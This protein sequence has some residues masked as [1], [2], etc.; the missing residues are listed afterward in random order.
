MKKGFTLIELLAVIVILAIIALIATPIV[1]NIISESKKS[2]GLRGAEMYL[3]AVEQSISI[4]KMN[5]ISFNPNSCIINHGNL[6]CDEDLQN[7]IKVQVNGNVPER[8]SIKFDKG[9]IVDVLLNYNGSTIVND[10]NELTYYKS[11]CTLASDSKIKPGNE[12]AKY[13]CKVDPNKDP[14][15]FYLLDNNQDGTS[16]LIMDQNINSDGTP[17][18]TV[19]VSSSDNAQKYNLV[20]WYYYNSAG[21]TNGYG[22][23]DAIDFLYNATKSWTNVDP[24]NYIYNDKEIQ[25]TE[26]GY[27]SFVSVDGILTLTSRDEITTNIIGTKEIPLRARMPIYS[28]DSTITEVTSKTQASYLYDNLVEIS[29]KSIYGYYTLSTY[30]SNGYEIYLVH[31]SYSVRYFSNTCS[32]TFD[33]LFGGNGF[34]VRPVITVKL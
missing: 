15:T 24:L 4:E 27:T 17:A 1:L 18:G 5:N 23:V 34:G 8:G 10:N 29:E 22:P 31:Y 16:D 13:N 9:K 3:D 19:A 33:Y 6:I 32:N 26:Y 28:S 30:P 11:I 14:Y 12:G 21:S 20:D 7:E 25:N 2:S